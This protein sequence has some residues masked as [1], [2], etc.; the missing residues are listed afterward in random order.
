VARLW[1][2]NP[3]ARRSEHG[4]YIHVGGSCN[5]CNGCNGLSE[6]VAAMRAPVG[7]RRLA[8]SYSGERGL[9]VSG[10]AASHRG[11][12]ANHGR[13]AIKLVRVRRERSRRRAGPLP[14]PHCVCPKGIGPGRWRRRPTSASAVSQ[15]AYRPASADRLPMDREFAGRGN[16][17]G[18]SN[19][20]STAG[21]YYHQP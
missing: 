9:V 17:G 6:S 5:A 4:S 11:F 19:R 10:A 1:S 12:G 20:L 13:P 2:P 15:V 3:L 14:R 8:Q 7:G 18:R 21:R 16:V